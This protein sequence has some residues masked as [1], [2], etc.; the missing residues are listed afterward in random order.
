M[1]KII[2][3]IVLVLVAIFIY[4]FASENTEETL[5][6]GVNTEQ[7]E[8]MEVIEP[9]EIPEGASLIDVSV[10]TLSWSGSK[11]FIANYTDS[12]TVEILEGFV[13]FDEE[14][15]PVSGE[16]SIDMNT[17]QALKTGKGEDVQNRDGLTGHLKTDDWF[18]VA[19]YPTSK[20]L[21]SSITR[22][23]GKEGVYDA[24]GEL[25][26]RNITNPIE[27]QISQSTEGV[28]SGSVE[29]DRSLYDVRFGSDKFF[30]DL[31]DSLIDDTF[32]LD[33]E[34]VLE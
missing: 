30:A 21:V 7:D 24:Q 1:K 14:G 15:N 18:N 20:V 16:A 5:S 2:W 12:G 3:F 28:L 17:I 13:A 11:T 19:E 8:S 34:I 10:S 26:I 33:F 22:A 6:E 27:F 23:E 4:N 9:L 32:I 25:I 31:G 29:V